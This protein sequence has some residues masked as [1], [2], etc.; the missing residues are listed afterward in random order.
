MAYDSKNRLNDLDSK[1]WLQFQKSWMPIE[2]AIA[3][4]FVAF[5]TKQR[6]ADG[7]TGR[8]LVFPQAAKQAMLQNSH[9]PRELI[10]QNELPDGEKL[11]YVYLD[12]SRYT[13]EGFLSEF[14]NQLFPLL[15]QAIRSLALQRYLTVVIQN[16]NT[17]HGRFPTAWKLAR[18]LGRYL[19]LKDEKIGCAS[20]DN[21][22]PLSGENRSLPLAEGPWRTDNSIVYYMNFRKEKEPGAISFDPAILQP[23][24]RV[25]SSSS[26]APEFIP[27]NFFNAWFIHKPPPRSRDVLLHPAKF[28]EDLV[29][30]FVQNFSR[31]GEWVLDPMAGTG[32]ALVAAASMGRKACGIELNPKFAQIAR[33]RFSLFE[34]YQLVVGDASDG[35][36]F[37]LLPEH[38][39]YC[40]TS[41]PYWDMLR[42]KGAE[43]QKKRKNAGLPR[44]YSEDQRDLGNIA[45]YSTF[46]DLLEKVYEHVSLR[47]RP[48]RYLT[49][50]VKNVKK[51]G[52][53]YPLAWDL[54]ARLSRFLEFSGEQI[55][56][57]DDQRLAPFG[58]RYAWV[59]NTFHHYCLTFRKPFR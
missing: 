48:G 44:W 19:A 54:A 12:F 57:Q 8:V 5:F 17:V 42:M 47:L 28:P 49:I 35:E 13:F 2:D 40:I 27:K 39:D 22:L 7:H 36:T 46:L 25:I 21:A 58:Y 51:K 10:L 38:V 15:M 32:S 1:Q 30:K 52:I 43:T 34:S 33:S 41:P 24:T 14:E 45:D 31:E 56:C 53:I 55:W 50:I 37:S 6:Y 59:S 4:Q 11:D 20:P 29:Q 18:W 23:A 26:E 3:G 16:H 9:P